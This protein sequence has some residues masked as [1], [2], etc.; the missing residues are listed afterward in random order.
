[1]HLPLEE[2]IKEID[3]EEGKNLLGVAGG[4]W[5]KRQLDERKTGKGIHWKDKKSHSARLIKWTKEEL[6]QPRSKDQKV[7][8]DTPGIPPQRQKG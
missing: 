6:Q 4:R 8:D 7:V 2:E 5:S 3:G 1:M